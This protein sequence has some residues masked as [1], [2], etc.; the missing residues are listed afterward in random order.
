MSQNQPNQE[1]T[2]QQ[3]EGKGNDYVECEI[4]GKQIKSSA[5]KRHMA[6]IHGFIT[7]EEF[8]KMREEVEKTIQTS[9][10]SALQEHWKGHYRSLKE[11]LEEGERHAETCPTCQAEL[12]EWL[13]KKRK[14]TYKKS[15]RR[16]I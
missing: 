12:K 10:H 3:E 16:W 11:L 6:G 5:Y 7:K 8:A 14:E 9:I 2:P 13:D 15:V 4:C 1:Q